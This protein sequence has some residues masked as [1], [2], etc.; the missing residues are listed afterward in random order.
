MITAED[1]LLHEIGAAEHWQES[2]YF[3][4]ADPMHDVFGLARIGFRFHQERVDGLI[5]TI[6]DGKPEFCYPA[7]SVKQKRPWSD[8]DPR[9]GMRA[10]G[11][12]VTM[13][14]PLQRWRIKL[15]G[16]HRMDLLFEAETPAF[17]YNAAGKVA[18]E[19]AG[20][21]FEQ[22]GRVTGFTEFKG[23]RLAID[24]R[25][26]RDKSWGV[27]DWPALQGWN[28]ITGLFDDGFSFN[29]TESFQHG[30][31]FTSGFVHH[32]GENHAIAKL[33]VHHS[34]APGRIHV[35]ATTRIDIVDVG[36]ARHEITGTALG[37]YPIGKGGAW[38]EEV[39]TRFSARTNGG[40]ERVGYGVVEHVW[41]PNWK[42]IAQGLPAVMKAN[43]RA[44]RL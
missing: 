11:F 41:R 25:G 20:E 18:D 22:S 9:S 40:A 21:H 13:E 24:A 33:N 36:G 12:T 31:A 7:V 29:A 28:W 8:Q 15:E 37:A 32:D 16:R 10:R 39:H 42:Q 2:F 38:I 35:P 27:R 44:M 34:F 1:E 3:N 43:L 6:R 17:D 30:E 23:T 26:Q 14:E 5:L 4:W 19:M